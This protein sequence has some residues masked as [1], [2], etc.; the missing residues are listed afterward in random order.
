MSLT[1]IFSSIAKPIL[2][3]LGEVIVDKDK[4]QELEYKL[5]ELVARADERYHEEMMG[6]IEINKEEAKSNNIFVSGWRPFIGWVG[7]VGL[8][9]TFVLAPFIEFFARI[10]GYTG[11]MPMP[12]AGQLLTLILGMLGIGGMR[13]FEKFKGVARS[14]L[15]EGIP[16]PAEEAE[17][18]DRKN[19]SPPRRRTG[20]LT[21]SRKVR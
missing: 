21:S 19:P 10:Y 13:T 5:Q 9:Y 3:I 17:E 14:N 18:G 1:G 4:K 20:A 12:D 2:D 6:Q 16:E 11:E 7:G 15:K 8:A